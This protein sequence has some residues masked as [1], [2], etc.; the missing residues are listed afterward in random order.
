MTSPLYAPVHITTL[1]RIADSPLA[2]RHAVEVGRPDADALRLGRAVHVATL[3]PGAYP[4]R[5]IVLGRPSE[6]KGEEWDA[7]LDNR[8][9]RL[10]DAFPR[11]AGKEYLAWADPFISTGHKVLSPSEW[12]RCREW[13]DYLDATEGRE[14]LTEAQ[15]QTAMD[16]SRA[17]RSDPASAPLLDASSALIEHTWAADLDGIACEGRIDWYR[18]GVLLDLK[19]T[20]CDLSPSAL[21]RE[22]ARYGYHIAMAWYSDAMT[23]L[24]YP[25]ERV[26]LIWVQNVA[27][28]D[29][30]V[31]WF[32][33]EDLDAGRSAYRAL[34]A[35]LRACRNLDR[36][37]GR[38]DG[39]AQ[40]LELPTW[41]DG[42]PDDPEI[43]F[44]D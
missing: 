29:V 34:L 35:T 28:Y 5:Y 3:E 12:E 2:Y 10:P 44:S 32:T 40:M 25:I 7:Y 16:I 8:A 15:N 1:K 24:G 38:Y 37:P 43:G 9:V 18:D 30:A 41:A 17:V 22:C 14:V 26:G 19:T 21:G 23:S 6:A 11:R 20:R 33:P 39:Q 42:M 36:C 27:P 31:T 4:D 13:A